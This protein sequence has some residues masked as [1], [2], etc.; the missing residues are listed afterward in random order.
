MDHANG[1]IIMK[2]KLEV[3]KD[4]AAAHFKVRVIS[5]Y[6]PRGSEEN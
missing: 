6:F 1:K 3:R 2:N 4:I 5:Q